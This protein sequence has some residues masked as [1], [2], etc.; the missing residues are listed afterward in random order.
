MQDNNQKTYA[1]L[2]FQYYDFG[3]SVCILD[4]DN[5]DYE[6]DT[7]MSK[8][9]YFEDIHENKEAPE[10][11]C[12]HVEFDNNQKILDSYALITE[13]G[14]LIGKRYIRN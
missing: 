7:H 6:S 5:W 9:V 4:S 10:K 14:N 3:D 8:I 2:E 12:F 1:D 13:T 11:L